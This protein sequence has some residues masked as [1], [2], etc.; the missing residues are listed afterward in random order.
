[1]VGGLE[2][3]SG[4]DN[5][6]PSTLGGPGT[7]VMVNHDAGHSDGGSQTSTAGAGGHGGKGGVGGAAAGSGGAATGSGGAATGSGGAATGSGGTSVGSGGSHATAGANGGGG[8]GGAA[9]GGPADDPCTACEK[10]RCSHPNLSLDIPSNSYIP[11]G[12][13]AGAME[14]CFTGTGWP[15]S[16]ADPKVACSSNPTDTGA[17]AVNGPAAGTAKTTLCQALLKCIHQTNCLGND[18]NELQCYCG[19]GVSNTTCLNEGFVPTGACN[20]QVAAALESTDFSLSGR[21]FDDAC[22]ANGAAYYIHEQCDENCCEAE[23]GLSASGYEDPTFCTAAATGGTSGSG[24]TVATGGVMGTGGTVATGGVIGTGGQAGSGGASAGGAGGGLAG[25]TGSTGGSSVS[26]GASQSW[27]FNVNTV[28]WAPSTGAIVGWNSTDIDASSQ[29][30][31]LD[32]Q[33]GT[34][35][36]TSAQVQAVHCVPAIAAASYK[37]DADILLKAGSTSYA[38]LWFYGSTDCSGSALSV[39]SSTPAFSTTL[40]EMVHASGLAPSSAASVAVQLTI[41]RSTAQA[42]AEALFDDVTV[43][44]E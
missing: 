21:F 26:G 14:V 23:C 31:S 41:M 38:A 18:N 28:G 29:S 37:L 35:S 12:T 16:V 13:L 42:A 25:S 22:L 4:T 39:A 6:A 44:A 20:A 27:T 17:T 11:Y 43:T 2:A 3:C 5:M 10:A 24:G 33:V 40:W 36:T 7:V 30:G 34:D 15:S 1:M 8:V 19:E 9:G 32:L